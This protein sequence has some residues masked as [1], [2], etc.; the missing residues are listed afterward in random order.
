MA[1]D[2]I[3]HFPV[4]AWQRTANRRGKHSVSCIVSDRWLDFEPPPTR[5][6]LGTAIFVDVMT[7]ISGEP[8]KL[9]RMCITLEQ[10]RRVLKQYD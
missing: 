2:K 5:V 4:R 9:C 3:V 10:L 1:D 7:E 6:D 8:R